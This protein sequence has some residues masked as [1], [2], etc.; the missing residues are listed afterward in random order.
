MKMINLNHISRV[1][2]LL[3]VIFSVSCL[4]DDD[5]TIMLPQVLTYA[6]I[7]DDSMADPNPTVYNTN[8]TI[9]NINYTVE[10]E[11]GYNVFRIDMPG[12][13][14]PGSSD[15]LTLKGTGSGQ[16]VWVEVDD[17]PKG[18]VVYNTIDDYEYVYVA[19]DFVFLV[20][21]SGSMSQEAD[22]I[23]RD[24]IYWAQKLNK[25]LDVKFGVVGYDGTIT[26]AINMTTYNEVSAF[27]NNGTGTSRTMG[28]AG[29]NATYL[30][31]ITAPYDLSTQAECGMAALHYANDNFDFRVGANRIYVN[32]TDEPNQPQGYSAFSV[33]YLKSQ[34]NWNTSLG[35]I[36]TVFSDEDTYIAEGYNSEKPWRMSEYTGGTILYADS[37]FYGVT[38]DLLPVTSAMQNSYIIKFANADDLLD[39]RQHRIEVVIK[40]DDGKVR[41]AKTFYVTYNR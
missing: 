8:T 32:F 21:N 26:G 36:H 27:L 23:A 25:T 31:Q 29:K 24:I 19:Y 38:L 15:W 33:D 22:A 6:G 9:P 39:G 40:T 17:T 35:T 41:A 10:N 28:F 5:Q 7:P 14:I 16:N 3:C 20:D 37:D 13:Q 4:K 11:D 34:Y 30:S 1:V 12:V 18:I 2:V